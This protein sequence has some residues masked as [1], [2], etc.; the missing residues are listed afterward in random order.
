MKIAQLI[1][2]LQAME[3]KHGNIHV[4]FQDPDGDSGPFECNVLSFRVA[5][6]DEF[7]ESYDMPEGFKFVLLENF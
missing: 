2:K 4:L 5:E 6:E 7:P 3:S 1:K